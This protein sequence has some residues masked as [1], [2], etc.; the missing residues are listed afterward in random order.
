MDDVRPGISRL[1]QSS[2]KP[3]PR[4]MTESGGTA[5][6]FI[7]QVVSNDEARP[8]RSMTAT[9]KFLPRAEG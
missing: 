4:C 8:V 7:L 9:A 3:I 2:K 5:V 6:R 1:Q